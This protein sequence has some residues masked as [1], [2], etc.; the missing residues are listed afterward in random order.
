MRSIRSNGAFVLH[1]I[2]MPQ[3][4]LLQSC[5]L[6]SHLVQWIE[7][8]ALSPLDHGPTNKS[9]SKNL[10]EVIA[11][12]SSLPRTC[13]AGLWLLANELDLSHEL[14]QEIHSAE[15]SYWH[16]IM[17]RREGDFE[18]AKYWFRRVGR[19]AVFDSLAEEIASLRVNLPEAPSDLP[20]DQLCNASTVATTLVDCCRRHK[21][22]S[23]LL[24]EI[25]WREWQLL[26]GHCWQDKD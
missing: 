18:N 10:E 6:P 3:A 20:W 2:S 25:C 7:S 21:S 8:T 5:N 22:N 15:G 24:G 13:Q 12:C 1:C 9:L 19:H 17:H 26:F 4:P 16:G 14:S 23:S 11:K